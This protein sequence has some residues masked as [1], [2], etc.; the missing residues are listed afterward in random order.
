MVV[1]AASIVT[2][3]GKALV[4]RQFVEMTRI[5][6]EGLLAAFPKLI[7]S[8]KQHTYVETEHVRYVS[9]PMESLYLLLITNK[10]SNILEDLETLRLL[11]KV[12]PDHAGA[13]DE[14]SVSRN[15]FELIFAFDE[16]ISL[17]H[18]ENVTLQQVR[19]YVEMESHEEKLH[20]MIIQSKINDTKDVM[21]KKAREIDKNKMEKRESRFVGM[22]NS[23][24]S[25]GS[26]LIDDDG[27]SGMGMGGRGGFGGGGMGGGG[28]D[29]GM[30]GGYSGSMMQGGFGG[31]GGFGGMS[32]GADAPKAKAG[33]KKGMVLGSKAKTSS[34]LESLKAEGE[35]VD[36]PRSAPGAGAAASAAPAVPQDP[37]SVAIEE[38]LVCQLRKDGGMDNLEVQGT[39]LLSVAS[40]DDAY[41]RV[42]IRTGDVRGF[43]FK[44][45]P[46]ID[47]AL[48]SNE[49]ILGLK[50]PNRPFPTG[51][52]LG[53][54]KWRMQTKDESVVPLSINCWPSVSGGETFVSIEYE[55]TQQFDLHNVQVA[56]PLP[57]LRDAPQVS[58][59]DGD[60]RWDSRRS[61]L[62][63]EIELIDNSN[64]NG[65]ME[66]AVPACDTDTFF[67][68][69]VG[70]SSKGTLCQVAVDSVVHAT[71]GQ[72]VRYSCTSAL[73]VE[74][75]QVA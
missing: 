2:K 24:Q 68:I 54:L 66:F 27:P 11:S 49:G 67:P 65:S 28:F 69:E 7:G 4:S 63:W 39:M 59:A 46:N 17:G 21:E 44:T 42:A 15:A 23:L 47:K 3:T 29:D 52:A 31:G 56:I 19:T 75:F 30:G 53:I 12:V 71:E 35:L 25:L 37:V 6:I 10:A 32:G 57:A 36:E 8:G 50:D 64:R 9:Q 14:E 51:S 33:P 62:F 18:K 58:Q 34:F 60:Y 73:Q 16:V 1:L 26:G 22:G 61:V 74:S 13:A 5:R 72:P 41:V 55:A 43:Q 38:K 45:H 48:H 70:F 20:K 40:E